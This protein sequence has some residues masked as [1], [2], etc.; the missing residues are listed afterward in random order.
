MKFFV[1]LFLF[2]IAIITV[3]FGKVQRKFFKH[4]DLGSEDLKLIS[5]TKKRNLV[6]CDQTFSQYIVHVAKWKRNAA[7]TF[8]WNFEIMFVLCIWTVV[9][10]L[11]RS[12]YYYIIDN[13]IFCL[14]KFP[15]PIF[16]GNLILRRTSMQKILLITPPVQRRCSLEVFLH[17]ELLNKYGR[18]VTRASIN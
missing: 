18:C 2:G 10:Y 14:L 15:L 1:P 8:D 11:P 4:I 12:F 17:T 3:L 9:M 13:T 5:P 16:T 7:I 6:I